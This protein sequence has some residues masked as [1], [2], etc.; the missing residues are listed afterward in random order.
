MN[1][2]VTWFRTNLKS[3]LIATGAII[4]SAQAF[5]SAVVAW[6]NGQPANWRSAIVSLFVAALGYVAK[7]STTHSTAAQVQ[8]STI[9]N[10]DIQA[11][12]VV[13]AKVAA[14]EAPITSKVPEVPKP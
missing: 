13:E 11:K 10:P 5:T 4:Y 7:D 14:V 3:N 9:Q 12:A 2:F 1:S 8:V 6:E